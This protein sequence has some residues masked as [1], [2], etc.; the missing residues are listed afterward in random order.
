MREL[1]NSPTAERGVL[2]CVLLD[3]PAGVQAVRD[4]PTPSRAHILHGD[5]GAE[6]RFSLTP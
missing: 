1:P 3:I 5:P 4:R 2:G 6:G